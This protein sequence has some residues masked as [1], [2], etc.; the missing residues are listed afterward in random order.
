MRRYSRQHFA[1]AFVAAACFAVVGSA[2]HAEVL[3]FDS[4]L[5]PENVVPPVQ[6]PGGGV[7]TFTLDTA[8][9]VFTWTVA[10]AALTGTVTAAH[11]HGPAEEGKNAGVVIP[12]TG[13]ASS[14]ITG[15]TTLTEAQIADLRAGKWYVNIHTAANPNGEIRGM[16]EDED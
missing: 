14:P 4:A 7:A 12:F 11:I 9:K 13:V 16:I 10:Y 6:S 15:S 2:A 5:E 8:T 1:M 3:R